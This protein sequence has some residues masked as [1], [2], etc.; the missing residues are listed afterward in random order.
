ML[1]REKVI[2]ELWYRIEQVPG[3]GYSA[4]NPKAEP[5]V[6]QM[7][8]ISIYEMNDVVVEARM[9]GT[10]PTYKRKVELIL[11]IF[12]SGSTENAA[13]KE[14]FD[15]VALV[16]TAIYRGGNNLNKKASLVNDLEMSRIHRP[17]IGDNVAGVGIAL[18]IFY[19]EEV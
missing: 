14:L 13:T 5:S 7:P 3:L 15:F 8:V 11:E 1:Q 16:Y 17:P 19:I 2:S 6:D 12:V 4:R 10:S 18:E 9:R